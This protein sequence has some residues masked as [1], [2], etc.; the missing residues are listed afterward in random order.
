[1]NDDRWRRVEEIYHAALAVEPGGR[2]AFLTRSCPGDEELRCEV[3]SLLSQPSLAASSGPESGPGG[4]SDDSTRVIFG[5]GV[6]VGPYEILSPLGAGGMGEVY[7]ARDTRLNRPVAIKFI[8]SDMPDAAARRRFQ[9]ETNAASSL[10]HPH[11][12]TVHEAGQSDGR[13]YLVTEFVDGGTL[14][15]WAKAEKR[16]WRQT[17]ELL[18]G[19]ADGLACAHENGILHRDIKPENVL[20][21]KGGYAK[22][23]DFGLAKLIAET[24]A[25]DATRTVTEDL[26][27]AGMVV[28][29]VAYMAPE[30]LQGEPV[31]ARSDVFSF[32]VVLYEMF[33]GARPF[34]GKSNMAVMRMVLDSA[35]VA[36]G[37]LVPGFPAHLETV[38][39]RCLEKPMEKRYQTARE[40]AS[41]LR[42]ALDTA[43][44]TEH[45]IHARAESKRRRARLAVWAVAVLTAIAIAVSVPAVRRAI[46]SRLPERIARSAGLNV[47]ASATLPP[48]QTELY[49]RAQ[50]YLQRYD[51]DGYIDRAVESLQSEL[52]LDP[53]NA[54]AFALLAQAYVRKNALSP[55][56]QWIKLAMES[57][58]RGVELN[59]DLAEAHVALGMALA[60]GGKIDE[61]SREL[62]RAG[63]LDALSGSARVALAKVRAAQS[64][65]AEAERLFQRA[66]ELSPGNWIPLAETGVFHY[67]NARYTEAADAWQKGLQI[68]PDNVRLMRN[69]AAAYHMLDRYAEAADILQRALQL[70]PNAQ[71]WANLGT[72]RFFEGRFA[73]AAKA[74]EKAVESGP[75]NYLFWGNLGDAY[76]W[77]PGQRSKAKATYTRAIQLVREKLA[78]SPGDPEAHGSLV[79]YLAKSGDQAGAVR[80]AT[81]LERAPGNTPG[82]KFKIAL[83]YEIAGKRD[84]AL[85]A[86]AAAIHAH[87]SMHEIA[88]E[89]ELASIRTDVRYH[90]LVAEAK[91]AA[92]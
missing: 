28:G 33:T 88:N 6:R 21:S 87:Y 75:T 36:P 5:P 66:V 60:E 63:N 59:G 52:N 15:H 38:V 44:I 29:T 10:N 27:R 78:L 92:K 1:M 34:E 23:A 18:V 26:T 61:A 12:V 57:A 13:P 24:G 54:G 45:S 2:L 81:A 55:D 49:L 7:K 86:L 8:L 41:D 42:A 50:S 83:G 3:E 62:E 70:K 30:Q 85:R 76:R 40:M 91:S 58:R 67:R 84:D 65:N 79:V 73:D 17:L 48:A 43:S 22:L 37:A 72:A 80:E 9:H 53:S 51:R 90:R 56:P 74:D 4:L 16:S 35:P 89:P 32:G 69:L 31:D 46:A 25:R 14:R 77:A 68:A 64:R 82:S 20:V 19:V 39:L 71:T 47:S 11:I